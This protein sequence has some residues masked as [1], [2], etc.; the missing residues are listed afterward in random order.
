MIT[1]IRP[2]IRPAG[3]WL[4]LVL[5]LAGCTYHDKSAAFMVPYEHGDFSR[6]AREAT[7]LAQKS[8]KNDRVI[9]RLEQ[10]ACQR[11]ADELPDSNKAFDRAEELITKYDEQPDIS[12]SR[13][14]LAALT[15]LTTLD[16]KGYCYDRIMM[17]VY[18]ALNYME[19]GDLERAR[20]ELRRAYEQQRA[21]VER[22]SK[23]IEA[24]QKATNDHKQGDFD[25]SRAESDPQFQGKIK[26]AYAN[27]PDMTA[28]E[29]Y[30]N[31]FAEYLQGIFYMSD[32]AG[33]DDRE[34]AATAFRRAAGMVPANQYVPQDVSLSNDV[35]NGQPL[36]AMTYVLF[37]TG[38]APVR[39]EF[40]IDI[41]V[42]LVNIVTPT[43]INYVGAAFPKLEFQQGSTEPL[44]IRADGQQYQT[45]VICD[46]DAVIAQEFNN[47][48][49]IVITKTLISA[50][51]KAAIAFA[52]GYSVRGQDPFIQLLVQGAAF[53]YQYGTTRADLRTWQTLPKQFQ[54]ARFPTPPDGQI[55]IVL[56]NGG[57][58]GP[59][60]MG[61][62]TVNI[63]Y[64]KNVNWA[65]PPKVR[66]FILK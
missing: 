53:G 36:P 43:Y 33:A 46:M 63:V 28:Y 37:E 10:G 27:V 66:Q 7:A 15:N 21:A 8:A 60:Q 41:P 22:F 6:A 65:K 5:S 49:P 2:L 62:D 25:V 1:M 35:A 4:G 64:I 26:Q 16:Y 31:P 9:F 48:L 23:Q 3:L 13:E 19:L 54:I 24:A 34:R 11:A 57:V 58:L 47:E 42:F 14:A 44:T 59:I 18:K 51:T 32:A 52:A 30:A 50:G 39:V 61:D 45:A 56:P 17:N 29:K 40:R 20:V 12:I 38:L 55:S